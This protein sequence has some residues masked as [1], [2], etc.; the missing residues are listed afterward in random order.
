MFP[1]FETVFHHSF[2]NQ[3]CHGL[4]W[5]FHCLHPDQNQIAS[6]VRFAACTLGR[7]SLSLTLISWLRNCVDGPLSTPSSVAH[8]TLLYPLSIF[9]VCDVIDSYS[10]IYNYI[11][12]Y[13]IGDCFDPLNGL[14]SVFSLERNSQ[15]AVETSIIANNLVKVQDRCF[16]AKGKKKTGSRGGG[17]HNRV[18]I[19][20]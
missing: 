2:Q 20:K 10:Y 14:I 13:R 8:N 16:N 17:G 1:H 3:N 11:Y 12:S 6:G 9:E 4:N 19:E 5:L 15:K 18:Y 7:S